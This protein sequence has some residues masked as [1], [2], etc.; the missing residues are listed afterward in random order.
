MSTGTPHTGTY[1]GKKVLVRLHTGERFIDYFH[2][3]N[4]KMVFFKSGRKELRRDI[5]AFSIYKGAEHHAN[6]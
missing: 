6:N 4:K 1:R 2:E 5:K 3:R